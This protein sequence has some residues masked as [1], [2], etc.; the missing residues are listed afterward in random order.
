M[1]EMRRQD[2]QLSRWV[3]FMLAGQAYGLP[4]ESVHEV[5]AEAEIEPVPG[6]AEQ[7]LGL[8]N[9]RGA[10]LTVIDLRRQLGLP[11]AAGQQTP[12]VV[13]FEAHEERF[14][15][16]VDAIAPVRKLIDAA[17]KPAPSVNPS[18]LAE[19]VMGLYT[20]DGDLLTLL[21]P[22]QLLA[23]TAFIA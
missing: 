20:R 10:V 6:A 3:C 19:R 7:V 2:D 1:N 22:Q 11:A 15:L 17:I 18:A 9:R 5:L 12:A 4:I 8:I 23:E 14:G 13:I 21:D 16:R